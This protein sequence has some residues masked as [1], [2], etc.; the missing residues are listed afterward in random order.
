MYI[1]LHVC[2]AKQAFDCAPRVANKALYNLQYFGV[3]RRI[4]AVISSTTSTSVIV[5]DSLAEVEAACREVILLE[6][7]ELS[8]SCGSVESRNVGKYSF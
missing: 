3:D 5:S 2:S 4:D 7:A 8:L 1:L 6:P